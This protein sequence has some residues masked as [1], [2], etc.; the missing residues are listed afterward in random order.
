[1]LFVHEQNRSE[2]LSV[3]FVRSTGGTEIFQRSSEWYEGFPDFCVSEYFNGV[4][5]KVDSQIVQKGQGL[6]DG[7]IY[8]PFI[9]EGYDKTYKLMILN[10]TL[11]N[12]KNF[13][14]F[15]TALRN[16]KQNSFDGLFLI[17]PK[18]VSESVI[19]LFN[20]NAVLCTQKPLRKKELILHLLS[21]T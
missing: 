5:G 3:V 2:L 16:N 10:L 6:K 20:A 9:F 14:R 7:T 17:K 15:I 13:L 18:E 4:I 1:M 21:H 19:K 8:N 11:Q 12:W